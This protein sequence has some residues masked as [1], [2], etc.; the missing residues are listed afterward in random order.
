MANPTEA[1]MKGLKHLGRFFVRYPAGVFTCRWQRLPNIL[2]IEYD[3]E[4]V[5][6]LGTRKS[7]SGYAVRL[8]RHCLAT[9]SK[10]LSIIAFSS[11]EAELY[12][13]V[14]AT[15]RGIG[16]QQMMTGLGVDKNKHSSTVNVLTWVPLNSSYLSPRKS[17]DF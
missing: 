17:F 11:R 6:C 15:S 10:H 7:A 1:G 5:G 14:S 2:Q 8:G 4:L 13:G 9:K 12:A 3:G 16:H